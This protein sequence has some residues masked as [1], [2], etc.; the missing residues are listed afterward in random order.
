M[1][2]LLW[3]FDGD[4]KIKMRG[5]RVERVHV[6]EG[7]GDGAALRWSRNQGESMSESPRLSTVLLPWGWLMESPKD[8]DPDRRSPRTTFAFFHATVACAP[9]MIAVGHV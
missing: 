2:L 8:P 3:G 6:N 9:W 5:R 7:R 1:R 4:G